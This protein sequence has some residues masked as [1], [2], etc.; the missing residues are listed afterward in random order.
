MWKR[1]ILTGRE[2]GL[3]AFPLE[4]IK[5]IEGVYNG[6]LKIQGGE[7]KRREEESEYKEITEK[8][9]LSPS[10]L[11]LDLSLSLSHTKKMTPSLGVTAVRNRL[12]LPSRASLIFCSTRRRDELVNN[13]GQD[14]FQFGL[15]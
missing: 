15:E 2:E 5:P 14:V 9:S 3:S 6:S 1:A 8:L 4:P 12:T 7:E 10:S 11:S 13:L